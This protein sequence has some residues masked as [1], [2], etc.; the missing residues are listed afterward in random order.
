[1][2]DPARLSEVVANLVKNAIEYNHNGGRVSVK[3]WSDGLA[4]YLRVHNTGIGIPAEELPR[5]FDRFYRADKARTRKAGGA[6]LGLA[7]AKRVIEDHGGA[8]TCQS[9]VGLGTEIVVR[10]PTAIDVVAE[11]G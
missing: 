4:A 11:T 10:L 9:E 1:V 8:M 3:V 5:V 2:G 7:I 6:G